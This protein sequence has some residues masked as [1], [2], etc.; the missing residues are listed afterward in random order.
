MMTVPVQVKPTFTSGSPA[1][2]FDALSLI[3]DGRFLGSTNRTF[4]ISPDGQRFIML[5]EGSVTND[6]NA[7]SLG[8]VVVQSWFDELKTKMRPAA[9]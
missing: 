8:M 6:G 1:K 4:D 7:P 2:L 5:Q 9:P 3:L